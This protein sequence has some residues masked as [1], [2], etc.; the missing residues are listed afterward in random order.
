MVMVLGPQDF[1]AQLGAV[2]DRKR[3]DGKS[4]AR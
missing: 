4:D 1:L 3:A 2:Q